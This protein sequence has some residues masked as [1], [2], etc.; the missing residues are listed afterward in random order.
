VT[1]SATS[2]ETATPPIVV[3]VVVLNEWELVEELF[4]GANGVV[5]DEVTECTYAAL[6][7]VE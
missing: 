5:K 4:P 3:T 7:L 6:V 1:P 2:G